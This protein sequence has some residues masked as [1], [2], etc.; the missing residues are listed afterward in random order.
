MPAQITLWKTTFFRNNT[1][2]GGAMNAAIQDA[3]HNHLI[4]H[5]HTRKNGRLWG[6]CTPE[7]LLKL[8]EDNRGIYE[9]LHAFPQKV[10][11]D[12]DKPNDGTTN[13]ADFI[14]TVKQI[15]TETFSDAEMEVSGSI[16]E[17]KIS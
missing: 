3:K 2:T 7:H 1:E 5:S 13:D 14:Q 4:I 15:I 11:F 9:V 10:Y 16:T 8:L 17:S 6:H 12:I